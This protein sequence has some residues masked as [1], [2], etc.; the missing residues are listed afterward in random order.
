MESVL[1]VQRDTPVDADRPKE[2]IFRISVPLV[3]VGDNSTSQSFPSSSA[4]ARGAR[5]RHSHVLCPA[6]PLPGGYFLF[7]YRFH[8]QLVEGAK[9]VRGG[10]PPLSTRLYFLL[11]LDPVYSRFGLPRHEEDR[12]VLQ[13][14]RHQSFQLLALEARTLPYLFPDCVGFI[15]Q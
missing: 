1:T 2:L 14:S 15:G 12:L 3:E 7:R 5:R 9:A 8:C 11:K 4:E 13:D 10:L 6:P